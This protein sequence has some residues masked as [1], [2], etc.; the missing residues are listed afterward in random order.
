MTIKVTVGMCVRNCARLLKDALQSIANQNYPHDLMEIIIVDDGSEDETLFI[1]QDFASK[2]DIQIK[3]YS[4]TWRGL[5]PS[6]NTIVDNASGE[7]IV[8]VDGDMTLPIDFIR[9]QVNFME[10]HPDVG[11]AKAKYGMLPK[12][13]TIAFLENVVYVIEDSKKERLLSIPGTGG[14]IY[15]VEAIRSVRFDESFKGAGE[16]LDVAYRVSKCGWSIRRSDA[17]FFERQRT[18]WKALWQKYFWWGCGMFNVFYKHRNLIKVYRMSPPASFIAGLI[19]VPL[20]FK[21]SNS[22]V[23]L[24]LPFH[25]AFKSMAW[26]LGFSKGYLNFMLNNRF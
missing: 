24:I 26:L 14:S 16:D 9:K 22:K 19:R 11:I 3:I 6:R 17:I 25:F 10:R 5:G 1:I 18:T 15:R 7:Y 23:L 8:W 2:T 20:G 21:L 4:Q 12:D 13:N